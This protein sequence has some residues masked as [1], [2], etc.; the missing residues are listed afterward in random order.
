MMHNLW[1]YIQKPILM[2]LFV[3]WLLGI[4]TTLFES[5]WNKWHRRLGRLFSA[6][7]F[8]CGIT[9]GIVVGMGL[10]RFMVFLS[11]EATS[12]EYGEAVMSG[13]AYVA[14]LLGIGVSVLWAFIYGAIRDGVKYKIELRDHY[15]RDAN[16]GLAEAQYKLGVMYA[17]GIG[18]SQSSFEAEEWLKKAAEQNN[19]DAQYSL[20]QFYM[21]RRGYGWLAA[22]PWLERAAENGSSD[23]QLQL[24][25]MYYNG[26][27]V[28][29]NYDLAARL[30][31]K[32]AI[33]GNDNAQA[34]IGCMYAEGEGVPRDL[35]L[36]YTWLSLAA[37]QGNKDAK[38]KIRRLG[39][40]G[41][42]RDQAR[43]LVSAWLIGKDI[44]Y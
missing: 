11:N 33:Q 41:N 37:S 19:K 4:Y 15:Q 22:I 17:K 30:M 39:L 14:V 24:G 13:R 23:A 12:D 16:N 18:V 25:V 26:R 29:Q 34:N 44:T 32:A 20:A 28:Q 6:M 38:K 10:Y 3:S 36:A 1:L 9:W 2:L 43:K 42:Q 35:V 8:L 5:A 31:R 40:K 21:E 7:Q 27:G